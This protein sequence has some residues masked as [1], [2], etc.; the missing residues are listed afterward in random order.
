MN[1]VDAR[2]GPGPGRPR[3]TEADAAIHS[4]VLDLLADVG[5]DALTIE[6][7]AERAGV[8]KSTVYRRYPG[9][10][11]LIIATLTWMN[12]NESPGTGPLPDTGSLEGDVVAMLQALRDRFASEAKSR[13]IPAIAGATARDPD[14]AA[15]HAAFI[16]QRRAHGR[17]LLERAVD[18][19]E[20]SPHTDL[21]VLVDLL[22]AT[23]YYRSFVS[24]DPLDDEAIGSIART[25]LAGHVPGPGGGRLTTG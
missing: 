7:V 1:A 14:L 3:S 25:A 16:A 8:A 2:P 13:I 22:S 6:A 23:V 17:S 24:R 19:G 5:Y 21:E 4:A 15:A 10:P 9:K 12:E 18:R 20:L 11:D